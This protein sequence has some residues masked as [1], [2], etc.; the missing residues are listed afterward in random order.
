MIG[1]LPTA[2]R[3]RKI[4]QIR[5]RILIMPGR[6][7]N[8]EDAPYRPYVPPKKKKKNGGETYEQLGLPL[9]LAQMKKRTNN[10]VN[11]A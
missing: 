11:E 10:N 8:P 6:E 9:R 5:F 2:R 4:R 1:T 3:Y 7:P